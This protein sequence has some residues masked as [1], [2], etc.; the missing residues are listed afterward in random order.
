[1]HMM[2]PGSGTAV[3]EYEWTHLMK[4]LADADSLT[5]IPTLACDAAEIQLSNRNLDR[6]RLTHDLPR[7]LVYR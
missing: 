4:M 5:W 1:M 6:R 2:I 7:L 3:W